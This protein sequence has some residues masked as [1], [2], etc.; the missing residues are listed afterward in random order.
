MTRRLL[1][2]FALLAATAASTAA[3]LPADLKY[4]PPDS[5]AF[6]YLD[7]AA[8]HDSKLGDNLKKSKA[9]QAIT[10]LSPVA[11]QAG[12]TVADVKTVLYALPNMKDQS[13]VFKNMTVVTF[14]KKYDR[15]KLTAALKESAKGMRGEFA[16][17]DNVLTITAPSPF[18]PD[19]KDK[20]ITT[21]DLTDDTRVVSLTGLG[22]EYRKPGD[23]QGLHTA[24]LKANSGAAVLAGVNFDALPDEIRG[25]NL[26][27]EAKPFRPIL[28]SEGLLLV[29]AIASD[30]LNVT[31]SVKSKTKADATEVEKSLDAFRLFIDA[32]ITAGKKSV[33]ENVEKP[34]EVGKLLDVVQAAMKDAKF[35]VNDTT[36]TAAFAMP[37]D[38]NYAP[39]FDYLTG[40]GVSARA[41]S[42]NNLKQLGIS[43]H[44]YHDTHGFLPTP[45]SL[46]KKGKKLL[47]WRVELLPYIEQ[48]NIYK[49]FHHDE[50]W[51][52][53]HNLKVFK[54]NPMPKVFAIP[55]TTNEADKKT[56]YQVF[57]GNGAIFDPT[58]PTK[59]ADIAD[60]TSNTF[61][62]ATAAKAVEWT[63]PDD[64]EFDPKADLTKLL[65]Y[66]DGVAMVAFADGSVRA[67]S[68]KVSGKALLAFVTRSGGEVNKD[69]DE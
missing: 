7:V 11:K 26:P 19:G 53:E 12:L 22:D 62:V 15:E 35:G 40:G 61:L 17:K 38:A 44:G 55:G 13:G 30:K 21:H 48:D 47:S 49:K 34:E 27:P 9:A 10:E 18:S 29:G 58:G 20:L 63:K 60:G 45:A 66:K 54:E 33:K 31:V 67:I 1:P 56:H 51:D 42:S 14:R 39:L 5:A 32:A 37:L 68:E 24:G 57:V 16:M 43:M 36:A 6:L 46:G 59:L 23:G 64:I 69:D 4:I 2:L 41:Q 25:E 28:I 3:D 65:L 50:P 52:S 8:L